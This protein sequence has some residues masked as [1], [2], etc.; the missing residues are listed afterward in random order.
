MSASHL[1]SVAMLLPFL[2][3]TSFSYTDNNAIQLTLLEDPLAKC[4]DATQ[5][6]YY[7]EPST[8]PDGANSSKWV[9]YLQ[10]GGEHI[11]E[12]THMDAYILI[13]MITLKPI[14]QANVTMRM[15]VS[16]S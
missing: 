11:H 16:L 1:F 9:F 15:R 7:Y 10:G 3:S 14:I 13:R 6:G 2:F 12:Y 8:T 5:S 4:L